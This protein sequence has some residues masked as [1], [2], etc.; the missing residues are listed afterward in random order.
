MTP[1][2]AASTSGG[3]SW[4]APSIT[5][6]PRTGV[7]SPF[8]T[9]VSCSPRLSRLVIEEQGCC[10]FLS[11]LLEIGP[12]RVTLEVGAPEAASAVLDALFGDGS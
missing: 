7:A 3:P 8:P 10:S 5:S 9:I 2:R 12:G 4:P 1:W 6:G 11:F